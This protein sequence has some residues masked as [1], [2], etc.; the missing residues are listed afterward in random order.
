MKVQITI[1]D[2]LINK[3]KAF[4]NSS[5][6]TE[7]VNIALKDWLVIYRMRE[8]NRSLSKR[9]TY[10]NNMQKVRSSDLSKATP[11]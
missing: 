5:T 2:D 1:P 11:C 10:V 9:K 4:T 7:A 6:V 3:V 8:L